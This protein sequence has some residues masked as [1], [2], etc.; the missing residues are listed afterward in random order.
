MT[1]EEE[2][3]AIADSL[4]PEA[5]AIFSIATKAIMETFDEFRPSIK[6][7][8]D[9]LMVAIK[10]AKLADRDSNKNRDN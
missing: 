9:G 3:N 5:G 1:E 4:S 7:I 2:L 8:E 10:V 6:D